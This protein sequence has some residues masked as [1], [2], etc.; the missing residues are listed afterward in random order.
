MEG[1]Y[2]LFTREENRVTGVVKIRMTDSEGRPR[3][4]S[5][6]ASR[7]LNAKGEA[8]GAIEILRDV[9]EQW[10]THREMQRL[11]TAIDRAGEAVLITNKD[12]VTEYVSPAFERITGYTRDEMLGR[13]P[14]ILRAE[15]HDEAVFKDLWGAG[16]VRADLE[17]SLQHAAQGRI[18]AHP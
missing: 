12:G 6:S 10:E 13:K 5:A 1:Q 3:H 18:A 9:T 2:S 16:V 15:E 11:A 8:T 17:W 4:V 7:L 14:R